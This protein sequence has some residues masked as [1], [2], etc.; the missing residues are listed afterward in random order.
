MDVRSEQDADC[1]EQVM[2]VTMECGRI[3]LQDQVGRL[4]EPL[5]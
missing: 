3:I 1:V 4:Q 2:F 5:Y